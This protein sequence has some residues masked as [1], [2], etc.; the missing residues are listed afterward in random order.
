VKAEEITNRLQQVSRAINGRLIVEDL[1]RKVVEVC[2][3]VMDADACSVFL[4]DGENEERLIMKASVGYLN[5]LSKRARSGEYMLRKSPPYD[6]IGVTAWIA[7]TGETFRVRSRQEFSKCVA[8]SGGKYDEELWGTRNKLKCESFCGTPLKTEDRIFGILKVESSRKNHFEKEQE[9]IL[10]II[11]SMITSAIQNLTV[12]KSFHSLYKNI[13]QFPADTKKL[14]NSLAKT[15]ADLVHAEACSLFILNDK[16][17][18]VMRGDYGHDYSFVDNEEDEYTYA[19]GKGVTGTVFQTGKSSSVSSKD[20]VETYPKHESKLYPKQWRDGKKHICHSWYQFCLGQPP[21]SLGVMKVEN[22]IGFNG[23]PIKKG[24]FAE[25]EK[26]ILE[27]LANSIMQVIS[28]GKERRSKEQAVA[29]LQQIGFTSNINDI[30]S[31]DL[32]AQIENLQNPINRKLHNTIT[33]FIKDVKELRGEKEINYLAL[34][35]LH[36]D[37]IGLALRIDKKFLAYSKSLLSLEERILFPFLPNYRAH[38]IHQLNVFLNGY[39][40]VNHNSFGRRRFN[41]IRDIISERLDIAKSKN[42]SVDILKTWFITTMF[43]DT[44]YPLG[45]VGNWTEKVI[46]SIFEKEFK[47]IAHRVVETIAFRLFRESFRKSL[48]SLISHLFTWLRLSDDSQKQVISQ[49]IHD[50]FFDKLSENLIAALI[51]LEA[52]EKTGMDDLSAVSSAVVAIMLDDEA[53]WDILMD[54]A[55]N[56]SVSYGDHP[57]AFLLVYSD[58]IQEYGRYKINHNKKIEKTGAPVFDEYK[59]V[60][61]TI[62]FEDN[63]IHCTLEYLGR[64]PY[65]DNIA[66]L[67][68]KLRK[69]WKAPSDIDFIISYKNHRDGE[70]F[71]IV[72][73]LTEN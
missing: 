40:I 47:D 11:A 51:L 38:F 71:D 26:Q 46:E 61:Q 64:P 25:T 8:Y 31:P 5:D 62:A 41:K 55:I 22:K 59:V 30:F 42:N 48:D 17:R 2:K 3:E 39:L 16:G 52:A 66:P 50:L 10:Q 34:A 58:N 54:K 35:E 7:V 23:K 72:H 68:A 45:K 24:G 18:L 6:K 60:K 69:C 27:I 4:I 56:K 37:K 29:A 9:F 36:I 73:F 12:I 19:S 33:E 13:G 63:K 1:A 43:H 28:A 53:M 20:K 57:L 65:W 14:Y 49:K 44:G 15:C 67:L 21:S 32:L 70:N